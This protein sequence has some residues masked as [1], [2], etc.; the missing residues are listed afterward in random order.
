M[1][2]AKNPEGEL[3]ERSFVNG[4]DKDQLFDEDQWLRNKIYN[5]IIRSKSIL[6]LVGDM[7]N[8]KCLSKNVWVYGTQ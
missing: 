4:I 1:G 6:L 2:R 5:F 7:I 3:V 8:L